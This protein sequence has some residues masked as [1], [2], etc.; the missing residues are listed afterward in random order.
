MRTCLL[1]ILP[2]AAAFHAIGAP[3]SSAMPKPAKPTLMKVAEPVV[4][5]GNRRTY[6]D[7]NHCRR[8]NT[9]VRYSS[10]ICKGD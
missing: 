7:F 10:R 2:L 6:R 1:L 3:T 9:S 8:L 5:Q 4:C